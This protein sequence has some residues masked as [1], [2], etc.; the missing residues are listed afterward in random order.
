MPKPTTL[1]TPNAILSITFI[2]NQHIKEGVS[3]DLYAFDNDNTKDLAIVHVSKGYKTP[4]QRILK[5]TKTTEGYMS[6]TGTLTITVE[7]GSKKTYIFTDDAGTN[8][9][10]ETEVYIGELMQWS[11]ETGL[12]FYEICEPPYEDSRFENLQDSQ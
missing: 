12:M 9:S 6:G 10:I 1:T 7:D 8:P 11:A 3:A 4:L 5:G 2:E